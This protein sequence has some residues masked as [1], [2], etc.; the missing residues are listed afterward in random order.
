MQ[1]FLDPQDDGLPTRE[2]GPWIAE[3]LDYLQ[4][5]INIFITSMRD[6]P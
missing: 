4:R 2:S 1:S 6:K 5:Y 3:K